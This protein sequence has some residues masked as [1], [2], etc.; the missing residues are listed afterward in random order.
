MPVFDDPDNPALDES[1]RQEVTQRLNTL[2][3]DTVRQDFGDPDVVA[4]I[5]RQRD[6]LTDDNGVPIRSDFEPFRPPVKRSDAR[7][8]SPVGVGE[9]NHPLAVFNAKKLLNE[10]GY[11]E[12]FRPPVKRSDARH[13]A[14]Q[15][16][17]NQYPVCFRPCVIRWQQQ[18]VYICL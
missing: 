11:C 15:R 3:S 4:Y 7:L 8:E 2:M 6:R 17:L 5:D 12:P 16:K 13:K 18:I 10:A 9:A 14:Q 1:E